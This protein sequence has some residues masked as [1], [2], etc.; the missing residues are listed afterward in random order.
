MSEFGEPDNVSYEFMKRRREER[1]LDFLD[2]VRTGGLVAAVGLMAAVLVGT[3]VENMGND[4]DPAPQTA[5]E[6]TECEASEETMPFTFGARQG[7]NN[8]VHAIEGSGAG[9][10]DACWREAAAA[11][12]AA[13]D[14]T[15]PAA[16]QRID[17]PVS[18]SPKE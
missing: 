18:V 13:L 8:A 17:I 5:D 2:R 10:G 4:S 6:A 9:E 7:S 3:A 15:P 1:R 12:E 11:V 16:G 14:D